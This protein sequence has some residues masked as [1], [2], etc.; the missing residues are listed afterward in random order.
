V[1]R[2]LNIIHINT[3]NQLSIHVGFTKMKQIHNSS[4]GLMQLHYI[5][6]KQ[7]TSVKVIHIFPSVSLLSL[8]AE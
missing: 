4:K 7:P 8:A 5:M 6:K 1:E 3:E 2:A